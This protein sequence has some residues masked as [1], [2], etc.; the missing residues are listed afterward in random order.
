MPG[1]A[2]I[3]SR[4]PAA[5]NARLVKTM[6]A[7]MRHES[8][9]A[10]GN[11]AAPELGLCAGWI[12]HENSFAAK[13]VFCNEQKDI[14]LVFSGECFV[15]AETKN[16]LKQ[17]GHNFSETGGDYLVHLYEDEG[18][19]FFEKLNGLFSGLL[20][21]RRQNKVFLYN[22]RYG[23]QR[24]Y[25]YESHGD[26]YFASEAKAL[27]RILPELR[28]FDPE[29]VAQFLT[30][31]CTL[32][33]R[34]LFRGVQTLPGGSVWTFE[35][36]NCRK[37][38]YFSPEI[39]E[40]QPQL[41]AEEFETKFQATF[42]K[43]LQRYFSADSRI[44]IALTGGL[45]TRMI[46]ACRPQNNGN[47]TCYTFAGEHGETLDDKIATRVA[48][49]CGL[50]HKL[51]R[52]QPDFFSDFA[53]HADKTVFVT[54][55]CFGISGAHEVYFHRQA[56]QLATVRLT[57]N[58]GSEVFRGIS[59]FKPVPLSPEL[60]NSD[61]NRKINFEAQKF[62]EQKKEPMS[63]TIF[64]EI[65]WN[66]FGSLAAGRSQ[67][68]FRTPYL[69]NELVALA[70]Q[71]P[72]HIRKSSLPAARLVK[73]N[74][75]TLSEIPTDRGF[76]GDNSGL[77]FLCRRAFA[78]VTFKMDYY[79]NEGL[80]RPL[81]SCDSAFKFVASKLKLAGLHKYLHYNN[82]FRHELSGYL[83]SALATP[84]VLQNRFWNPDFLKRM[85]DEHV[86]GRKN[87]SLEINAVL[88][89]EAI[90]R[91]LFRELPRDNYFSEA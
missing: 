4:K 26:F 57:G 78:E 42:K 20:I 58:Y 37:E 62:S 48:M 83:R 82:W 84:Q 11:F 25:F 89:L 41:P 12:A 27:L 21:D 88:T 71:S 44:G 23:S 15:D 61:L 13:Q 36:G 76:A 70:Y 55:G 87:Y 2:G 59:T 69:D 77:K 63:F 47:Q 5:E 68:V 81:A 43:I 46:M 90:E 80:P 9:Y 50:D 29:G 60:F 64:K 40:S 31:G 19:K 72:E 45:D 85:A 8:F 32:D 53:A 38:N 14:T 7:A 1:I 79:N 75:K 73:A 86:T 51:L 18:E 91:L 24:I 3:I 30:F 34:T 28:E 39:W 22:D 74:N 16:Q 17:N 52:L 56:R 33:W 66:L 67:V 35:N 6:V 10:T 54:D 65:P 49:A